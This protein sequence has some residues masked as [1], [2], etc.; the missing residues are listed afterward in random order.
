MFFNQ[1]DC[2]S[3]LAVRQSLDYNS[4][5]RAFFAVLIAAIPV[6]IVYGLVTALLGIG[7]AVTPEGG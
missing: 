2:D 1:V 3:G 7:V 4:T 6:A 5:L